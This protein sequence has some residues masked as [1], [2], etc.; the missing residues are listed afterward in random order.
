MGKNRQAPGA[1]RKA[2]RSLG[3]WLFVCALF[4]LCAVLGILQYRAI[5]EVSIAARER[6]RSSL[7]ASLLALSQDFNSE[8]SSAANALVPNSPV[9]AQ[10]AQQSFVTLYERGS[11]TALHHRLFSR[12][13]MGVP[14]KRGVALLVFDQEHGEWKPAEWPEEWSAMRS[15][16]EH[17]PSREGPGGNGGA[18]GSPAS[19]NG[20]PAFEIPLFGSSS[21]PFGRGGRGPGPGP[22]ARREVA[23]LVFEVSIPVVRET[24]LPEMLQRHLGPDY[25]AEVVTRGTPREIVYRTDPDAARDLERTA[26]A[27]VSLF[28]SQMGPR[29]PGPPGGRGPGPSPE[30]GR[31]LIFVRHR[32][33]SLEA[34]V[35]Q[36]RWRSMAVTAGVLLMLIATLAALIR[37]TR[38][39]Q[40]LAEL[41]M[42][43]VAGVSHELRTPLTVIHTA[44]YNLRGGV[45]ANPA[46]VER[47]GAL[48][49]QESGR[50]KDLVEQ[51]LRFAGANAGHIIQE[52]EPL[53]VEALLDQAI[54]ASKPAMDAAGCVVE[55]RVDADL[56]AI[57]GDPVAL[58]QALQNLLGNAAKYGARESGWIG[59][60]ASKAGGADQPAIEIRVADRGPGIPAEEQK[61]IFDPFFRGVRAVQDQVHGT[62]LGLSLVKKIVAAHGGSIRVKSEPMKGAEFIVRLPAMTAVTNGTPSATPPGGAAG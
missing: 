52:C 5:A 54:A 42:E 34:V 19:R 30:A 41:Q 10:A 13:A 43:F 33:G 38:R 58:R 11:Q 46:Q 47:Y 55:K 57:D 20:G 7:D 1:P 2:S 26:D 23:W 50:L 53:A 49:Q 15:R 29:R 35:A 21:D 51:V 31:W 24:V 4:A 36:A 39:A 27:S 60:G 18:R 22:S 44:A 62:G 3:A 16:F 32:A 48:I 37:Y 17:P 12:I 28:D 14:Q 56:P 61:H 25:Q 6:L 9:D 59:I 45:A 8:I 40:T